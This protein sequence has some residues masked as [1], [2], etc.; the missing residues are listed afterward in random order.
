MHENDNTLL[1][2]KTWAWNVKRLLKRNRGGKVKA[3]IKLT[4]IDVASN[5][6]EGRKALNVQYGFGSGQGQRI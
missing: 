1:K 5:R 2:I 6:K 3:I 4:D